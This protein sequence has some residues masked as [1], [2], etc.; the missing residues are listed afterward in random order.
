MNGRW[1]YEDENGKEIE[2]YFITEDG[3]KSIALSGC[4]WREEQYPSIM[5]LVNHP[6]FNNQTHEIVECEDGSDSYLFAL[7]ER[8]AS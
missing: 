8:I 7:V 5:K 1:V 2:P 6:D 4:D 3:R